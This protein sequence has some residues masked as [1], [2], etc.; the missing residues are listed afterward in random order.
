[1]V[2]IRRAEASDC[3]VLAPL[4]AVFRDH[5]EQ[6]EPRND[7]LATSLHRL[8]ADPDTEFLIAWQDEQPLGY[9]QLRFRFSL[10][11]SGLEAQLD[12]LFVRTEFRAR[13]VGARLLD[14]SIERARARGSRVV[15]LNTNEH[16]AEALRLYLR[17]GF[18]AE[19]L[20]WSG[21]RQLWL[22]MEP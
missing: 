14:A 19:R 10:W 17:A 15:G 6:T 9:A 11:V 2:A 21:G 12:D 8:L 22:E 5:L 13:G 16:N 4:V 1:M 3:E 20:R 7:A 18:K